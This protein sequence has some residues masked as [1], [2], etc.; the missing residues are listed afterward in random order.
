LKKRKK[1][2]EAAIKARNNKSKVGAGSI[3]RQHID[4]LNRSFALTG[5]DFDKKCLY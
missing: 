2:T 3:V 5:R 4:S 1:K